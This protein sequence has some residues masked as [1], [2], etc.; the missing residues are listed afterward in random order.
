M[1]AALT[2][3]ALASALAALPARAADEPTR[4]FAVV[5]GASLGGPERT[6]LRYATSDAR[7]IASVLRALG[8]V[9]RE[10]LALVEEPDADRLRAAIAEVAAASRRA[11]APGRRVE[12]LVYYSGHSDE[13]GLLLGGSRLSYAELRRALEEVDADVRVAILDSCASGAFTRTKGGVH[14]PAFLVDGA[15]R[16]KGHAFLTSSAADEASQESDR[17]R[18]SFF[19]HALLTGLRGAADASGDGVV[20]L[21]EAY[22]FAFRET[23]ARTETTRA[24]AQHPTFD[25]ALVGSGEVVMT[26]LR[27]ADAVLAVPERVDGRVFVRNAAGELV[28]E[29]RKAPG[30]RVELALEHGSYDVRVAHGGRVLAEGVVL[31]AAAHVVLDEARLAAVDLEATASR[32][33]SAPEGE[34]PLAGAGASPDGDAEAE[35]A[36]WRPQS[37][38]VVV[39]GGA[40]FGQ[41]TLQGKRGGELELAFGAWAHRAVGAELSIGW[42]ATSG[43][44]TGLLPGDGVPRSTPSGTVTVYSDP[45]AA[46]HDR[47]TTIPLFGTV[48]LAVPDGAFRPY[49]LAGVGAVLAHLEREPAEDY[50]WLAPGAEHRQDDGAVAAFRAGLGATVRA[51]A[52]VHATMEARFTKTTSAT[53]L[54]EHFRFDALELVGGVGVSF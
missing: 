9:A 13:Q 24:G 27:R 53:M 50:V 33:G 47:L 28:A 26:D 34:T 48:R 8:G 42:T 16:V 1:R 25:I 46:V 36:A 18:G 20:T 6:P 19:T 17:I 37:R 22:Q 2:S 49:A 38:Y 35:D 40:S 14:G 3:L 10:D 31:P 4:R 54:G 12:L 30:A 45:N 44:Q 23:L 29:L 15:S 7:A 39:R 5:A 41:S 32:G 52:G 43:T 21:N 11:R 51:A